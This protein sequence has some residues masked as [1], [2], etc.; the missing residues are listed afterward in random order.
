MYYCTDVAWYLL[1]HGKLKNIQIS[2]Q[3][4]QKL[5]YIAHGYFLGWKDKPLILEPIGAWKYGPIINRIYHTF[6]SYSIKTI[7][8]SLEI[9]TCLDSNYDVYQVIDGILTLYGDLSTMD[10]VTLTSQSGSPCNVIWNKQKDLQNNF[11]PINNEIIKNHY[12]RVISDP[13]NVNGL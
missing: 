5:V 11:C 7:P 6:K 2:N 9:K 13:Q 10:L 4:L 8:V 1:K 12:R 3:K